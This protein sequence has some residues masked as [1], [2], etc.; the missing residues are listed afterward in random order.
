MLCEQQ[1]LL[2]S[3][4]VKMI[5]MIGKNVKIPNVEVEITFQSSAGPDED[6]DE[7][8]AEYKSMYFILCFLKV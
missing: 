4:A 7:E 3:A 5:S 6:D 1:W 2:V 8:M